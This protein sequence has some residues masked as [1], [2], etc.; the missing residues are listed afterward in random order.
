MINEIKCHDDKP[1]FKVTAHRSMN[2]KDFI[3]KFMQVNNFYNA[4]S[5]YLALQLDRETSYIKKILDSDASLDDVLGA[6]QTL[7]FN[8]LP[9]IFR[10]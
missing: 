4:E 3:T 5:S 10:I 8:N 7:S 1:F 9:R 2:I 6:P